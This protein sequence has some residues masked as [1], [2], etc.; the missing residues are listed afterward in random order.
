METITMIGLYG[1]RQD[2][3]HRRELVEI[4]HLRKR[5][6]HDLLNWDVNITDAWE[7]D[8][9]DRE[10]PLYVASYDPLT[11]RLRG[12]LRLLPT[13]GPNMLNDDFPQLLGREG[14]IDD[15][16]SW[17]SSRFCIDPNISQDRASNQVTIAAAELMC[18]VGELASRSGVTRIVTVT[19]VFL[20]RMF[21]RMGCPAARLG[22]P[23]RIG[24]VQAVAVS[25]VIDSAIIARMKALAGI[26]GEVLERPLTLEEARRAA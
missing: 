17:E 12:S 15:V 7:T 19:D 26:S 1:G 5:V 6:F 16:H 18:G 13:T 22:E 2:S 10:N 11:G 3:G 25:W 20:E 14:P 8:R 9:Y 4:Y 24:D 21:R 23:Q